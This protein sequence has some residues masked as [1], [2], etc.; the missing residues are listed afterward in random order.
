MLLKK[1]EQWCKENNTSIA[2]LESQCGL[3]NATIRGWDKSKPRI[4]S[5]ISVSKVTKI[6]LEEL[7]A[8]INSDEPKKE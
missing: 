5:L 4:D 6:P 2:A 7:A 3:G 1:I 8:C